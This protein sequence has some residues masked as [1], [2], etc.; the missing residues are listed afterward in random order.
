M[1]FAR[2]SKPELKMLY[3]TNLW[4]S[5]KVAGPIIT[6]LSIPSSPLTWA[7]VCGVMFV[8]CDEVFMW[9]YLGM[10]YEILSV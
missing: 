6:L 10:K 8:L 2:F 9:K 1:D 4:K 5:S 3:I 7:G